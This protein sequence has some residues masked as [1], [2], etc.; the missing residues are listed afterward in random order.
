VDLTLFHLSTLA[1]VVVLVLLV[2]GAAAV[3]TV[4]GRRLRERPETVHKRAT[5]SGPIRRVRHPACTSS[6]ST[7]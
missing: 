1:V 7:T 4:V 5:R 2:G 3:G 6:R